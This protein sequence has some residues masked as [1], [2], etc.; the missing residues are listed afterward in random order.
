M[1]EILGLKQCEKQLQGMTS[2]MSVVQS[3]GLDSQDFKIGFDTII[4]S[5]SFDPVV[6]FQIPQHLA[7]ARHAMDIRA[8][9][10]CECFMRLISSESLKD[11]GVAQGVAL[12]EQVV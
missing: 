2:L 1:D 6:S 4:T 10:S 12:V 3:H 9:D 7:Y 8:T 11:Q 5:L